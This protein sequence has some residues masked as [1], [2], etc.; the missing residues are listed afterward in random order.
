MNSDKNVE[1]EITTQD[2]HHMLFQMLQKMRERIAS[3]L[4]FQMKAQTQRYEAQAHEMSSGLASQMAHVR[5]AMDLQMGTLAN[6][7]G[8][9]P[10][11]NNDGRGS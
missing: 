2:S 8:T 9:T 5:G 10:E 1:T 7:I 4:E 3:Q 6:K 11:A